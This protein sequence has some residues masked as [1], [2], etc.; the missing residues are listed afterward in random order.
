MEHVLDSAVAEL[1]LGMI[2]T[3]CPSSRVMIWR[4]AGKSSVP[5]GTDVV[6]ATTSTALPVAFSLS[7]PVCVE[8]GKV[9]FDGNTLKKACQPDFFLDVYPAGKLVA[10]QTTPPEALGMCDVQ[11]SHCSCPARSPQPQ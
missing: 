3:S 6:T 2:P 7:A 5:S 4:N 8:V 11:H 10:V 1:K 9:R